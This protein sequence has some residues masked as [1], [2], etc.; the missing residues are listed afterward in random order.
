MVNCIDRYKSGCLLCG[1]LIDAQCADG[2]L[3]REAF[4]ARSS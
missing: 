3:P 2:H 4:V 1:G